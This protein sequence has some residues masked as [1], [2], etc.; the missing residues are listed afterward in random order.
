L[1]AAS[2]P[3][4]ADLHLK[5]AFQFTIVDDPVI[6]MFDNGILDYQAGF[7]EAITISVSVCV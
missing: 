4:L 7:N 1:V 6:N 3:G 2:V 5:D